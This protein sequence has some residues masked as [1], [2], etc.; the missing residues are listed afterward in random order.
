MANTLKGLT[1]IMLAQL[2]IPEL[3]NAVTAAV[4]TY[5]DSPKSLTV[6]AAPDK[7]VPLPMIVGAAMGAPN[8][9]PKVIG[10]KVS[11]NN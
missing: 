4:N 10:L 3:Q 8:T 7:P 2:N 11:A 9:I 1:P 6:S 5:L